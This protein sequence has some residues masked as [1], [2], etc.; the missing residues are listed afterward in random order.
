M[1]HRQ[2]NT[3]RGKL[4]NSEKSLS[5]C[6]SVHQ[7]SYMDC[8]GTNPGLGSEKP[9]TNHLYH[10]MAN[11]DVYYKSNCKTLRNTGKFKTVGMNILKVCEI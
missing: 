10:G 3:G 6:N 4:N 11:Y 9:A 8:P 1:E 2:N 7:K 5:Q